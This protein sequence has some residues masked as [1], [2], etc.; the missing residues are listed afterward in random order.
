[1]HRHRVMK[2]SLTEV[3]SRRSS[4]QSKLLLRIC[5][6]SWNKTWAWATKHSWLALMGKIVFP[7]LEAELDQWRT[8]PSPNIT[9]PEMLQ[10]LVEMPLKQMLHLRALY[11][12]S[13]S[14][15]ETWW[16]ATIPT[17]S[18]DRS[19]KMHLVRSNI[20]AH[21]WLTAQKCK[22]PKPKVPSSSS[23]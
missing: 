13:N 8:M 5:Q 10:A 16:L 3:A 19:L 4:S 12:S 1:M 18:K 7:M 6:S 2:M 22:M 21:N 11:S 20:K 14:R 23:L 9:T 17:S 15:W